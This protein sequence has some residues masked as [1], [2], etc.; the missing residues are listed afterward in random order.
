MMELFCL[1]LP[2]CVSMTI[3]YARDN[4]K[5]TN[6]VLS[7]IFR[8]GCWVLGINL[9]TMVL[10]TYFLGITGVVAEA[11]NSFSFAMK[12]TLIAVI[13]AFFMTYAVEITKKYFSISFSIGAKDEEK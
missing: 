12:Y 5:R 3:Q 2:A 1:L 4:N 10:V 9:I 7:E 11:F 8:F 6:T 13:V